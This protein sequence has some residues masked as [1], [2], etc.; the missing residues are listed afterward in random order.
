MLTKV[1]DG[2][3][4]PLTTEEETRT[5]AEWAANAAKPVV[6]PFDREVDG[7]LMLRVL[8]SEL[9]EAKGQTETEVRDAMKTKY[10][11]MRP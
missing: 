9:A 4:V 2:V 11:S 5:R 1:V 8:I 7:N 3:R 6:D 10:R